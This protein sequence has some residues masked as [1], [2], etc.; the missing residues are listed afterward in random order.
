MLLSHRAKFQLIINFCRV[1]MYFAVF[2]PDYM[3][4]N[5]FSVLGN[6]FSYR[7]MS[8]AR[9]RKCHL[10]HLAFEANITKR[11]SGALKEAVERK[12]HNSSRRLQLF[13]NEDN[14]KP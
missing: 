13:K 5:S 9:K 4:E 8:M 7:R 11:I 3:C 12:F 2:L 10:V 1:C 14:N 6:V